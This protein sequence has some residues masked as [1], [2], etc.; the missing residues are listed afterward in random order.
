MSLP[1][2]NNIHVSSV[3]EEIVSIEENMN[4]LSDEDGNIILNIPVVQNTSE[5]SQLDDLLQTFNLIEVKP[6]LTNAQITFDSLRYL[7]KEDI[8]EAIPPI[9]IRAC[10]REK[11]FSWRKTE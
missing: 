3:V 1:K 4:F 2:N 6:Y 7:S 8:K 10:F 11:L 9:G 5:N